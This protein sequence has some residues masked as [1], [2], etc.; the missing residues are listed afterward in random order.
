[1]TGMVTL[2]TWEER[3]EHF[4][5]QQPPPYSQPDESHGVEHV[6]RVVRTARSIGAAEGAEIQVV[7]PAAWLHDCVAVEKNSS[8]RSR[9][10]TLAADA[11]RVFLAESGY[12]AKYLDAIHH[13][14]RAHSFSA[15]IPPETI[16]AKV[17]Q[18]ADRLDALGAIGLAR[19]LMVGERLG[20]PLYD[21]ADPFCQRRKPEDFHSTLDHFYT[22]LLTLPSTMQTAVGAEEAERRVGF[23]RA[24]LT[25]L[26]SELRG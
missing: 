10:S 6:R 18:D 14:I 3:C 7:V 13:A 19:C 2:A 4:L 25:Q 20:R 16:E 22:K 24:F 23:L 11:A 21:P 5:G 8:E 26:D 12:P 15:G 9:A 17:V 1:M